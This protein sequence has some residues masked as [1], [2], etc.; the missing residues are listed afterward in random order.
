MKK[1]LNSFIFVIFAAL[2]FN[3]CSDVPAPYDTPTVG[4]GTE[5]GGG[6]TAEP[7]G[8]GTA[9]DPYNVARAQELIA[10]GT[11]TS[12]KVYVKGIISKVDEVAT[13]FGNATYY[14]S[15]DGSSAGELLIY[16]GY[17]L[18]GDKFTSAD[19]I[20]EGDEVIVYG[21]LVMFMGNTPEMT[22]YNQ[23]YSLNGETAGGGGG[24]PSGEGSGDG[25]Q[26][27]PYNVAAAIAN[28]DANTPQADIS[29]KGYIVGFVTGQVISSGAVF[30]AEAPAG[31]DKYDTN[32]LIADNASETNYTNC[33]V[34]QLPNGNV[35]T[36]LNL[37]SNPGNL[38]KMV[39][40]TGSLE[41]YFGTYGLKSV[42]SFTLDGEGG[43][44]TPEPG[45]T[46]NF[47]K[48]TTMS[49]GVYLIAAEVDGAYKVAQNV[50]GNY[51]YLYVTDATAD[52]NVISIAADGMTFTF[53]STAD[54][55]TITD[56]SGKYYTMTGDFN[57][58]NLTDAP[59][60]GQYWDVTPN[61]DGT[62]R[63]TN[64]AVNKWM[65]YSADY[66]S[67]GVYPDERGVMPCLFKQE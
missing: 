41:K 17:Y 14:I 31:T 55:Y 54:G 51:G 19:Q 7:A 30:G 16:R 4:D 32:I 27:N 15:D 48:V 44:S 3:A 12:D 10:T 58:C 1:I 37:Q 59:T 8:T 29:V 36:T 38:G 22:Q 53:T 34:I 60:E 61:A 47:T 20:K 28:Y 57:S 63:I 23:I 26:A 39:T 50:S 56:N 66:T 52:G 9:A 24:E 11:Y 25:T 2:A 21:E 42:T 46:T 13:D 43:G 40:L 49:E 62:F 5:Q 65:Q 33:L 6:S 64:K 45:P 67:Y 18:G 35:R